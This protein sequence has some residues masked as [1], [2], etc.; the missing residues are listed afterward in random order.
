MHIVA[1]VSNLGRATLDSLRKQTRPPDEVAC[2][3]AVP[4]IAS[5]VPVF[6][7]REGGRGALAVP[8][9]VV[10]RELR[11]KRLWTLIVRV[12]DGSTFPPTFFEDLVG[13]MVRRGAKPLAFS[14]FVDGEP[15]AASH[16]TEVLSR[17]SSHVA[18]A[19]CPVHALSPTW[20][21]RTRA[22]SEAEADAFLSRIIAPPF[23]CPTT[24]DVGFTPVSPPREEGDAQGP[25]P[26]AVTALGRRAEGEGADN[27]RH[28]TEQDAAE[29]E[30]TEIER[31]VPTTRQEQTS[32]AAPIAGAVVAL[33]AGAAVLVLG[34][35]N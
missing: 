34:I 11:G 7:V 31:A 33:V 20:N 15:V 35:V 9:S 29:P 27:V 30:P 6:H 10:E 13:A 2:V 8:L 28:L 4:A 14:G 19:F 1:C 16:D 12:R 24:E 32:T 17:G 22:S 25:Q 18:M 23:L 3:G 5:F 21:D 26:I